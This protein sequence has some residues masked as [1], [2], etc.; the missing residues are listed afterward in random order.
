MFTIKRK[1]KIKNGKYDFLFVKNEGNYA[2]ILYWKDDK[3]K[4]KLFRF[5]MRLNI[6]LLTIFSVLYER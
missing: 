1:S 3:P 5:T 2:N 6:G 4:S